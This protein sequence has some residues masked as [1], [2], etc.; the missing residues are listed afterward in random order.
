MIIGSHNS[1]SY[2]P[3]KKWWMT[4]FRFIAKCQDLTI[5]EQYNRGVRCFD[6]RVRFDKNGN[7][8][9]CH[10]LLQYKIS[11]E[12]LYCDLWWLNEKHDVWVRVLH[13]ARNKK[14][15]TTLSIKRFREYCSNIV[16]EFP[17]IKFWNGINLYNNQV[18][19]KFYFKPFCEEKYSSVCSLRLID[20]WFPRLY[21]FLN[22]KKHIKEGTNLDIL[23]LDFI[24]YGL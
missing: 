6:L 18:D 21:A 5:I 9:L 15:Y 13:E 7:L 4:P 17:Y 23:L 1:W 14:Q 16:K 11:E 22:T 10:G 24:N 3:S 12:Q 19:Y 20:D 8:M 2:L